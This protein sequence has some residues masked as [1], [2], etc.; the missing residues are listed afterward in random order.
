[1]QRLTWAVS[2]F[3]FGLAAAPEYS[4]P[5]FAGSVSVAIANFMSICG[6]GVADQDSRVVRFES[7]GWKQ[8]TDAEMTDV[9]RLLEIA[10]SNMGK[11]ITLISLSSFK[12]EL[13][14]GTAYAILT[15]LTASDVS[16]L[17]CNIYVP[18]GD[19]AEFKQEIVRSISDKPSKAVDDAA[20]G[21][22]FEWS[23]P[24]VL[25]SVISLRASYLEKGGTTAAI[26]GV[27][28]VALAMTRLK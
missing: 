21:L 8:A 5:A 2:A 1:V 11:E 4:V 24:S 17:G 6:H 15:D 13:A 26:L 22:I 19:K 20:I 27:S 25:P 28:G 18:K 14:G 12:R 10:R 23:N 7:A 3:V 16:V 9:A